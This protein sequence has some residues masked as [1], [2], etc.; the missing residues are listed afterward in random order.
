MIKTMRHLAS[1]FMPFLMLTS[2]I[3]F[4]LLPAYA[5][6]DTPQT[7]ICSGVGI[8]SA[9]GTCGDNG[10]QVNT[11]ILTAI[12]LFSTFVGLFAVVMI[13]VAGFRFITSGGDPGQVSSAKNAIIYA[14][15]GIVV[16][17]LSQF[18]VHFVIANVK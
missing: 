17:V 3:S 16:V 7:A 14:I 18:I 9:N 12:N 2:V 8:A 5:L 11:V 15:I 6:A 4:V 13:I 10:A 1:I